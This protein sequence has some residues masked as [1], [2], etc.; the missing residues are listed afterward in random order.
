MMCTEILSNNAGGFISM[1]NLFEHLLQ[2]YVLIMFGIYH[3][4]LITPS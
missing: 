2:H 4:V 3:I 1:R